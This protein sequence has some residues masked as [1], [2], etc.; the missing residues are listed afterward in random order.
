[1]ASPFVYRALR[2]GWKV[3]S[4]K[5]KRVFMLVQFAC[6]ARGLIVCQHEERGRARLDDTCAAKPE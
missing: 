1:M 3:D 2:S 4:I 6:E 5:E